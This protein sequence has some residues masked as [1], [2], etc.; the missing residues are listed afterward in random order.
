MWK[1]DRVIVDFVTPLP[2]NPKG[3]NSVWIIVNR[4]IKVAY[5]IPFSLGQST[6]ILAENDIHEVVRLHGVSIS[7]I[8][9][10]DTQFKYQLWKKLQHIT[11]F[12]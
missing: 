1:W 5:F 12:K 10:R 7:I 3:N 9:D 6:K 2:H 11:E 8:S 4:F